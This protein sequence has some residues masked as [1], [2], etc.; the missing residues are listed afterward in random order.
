[1]SRNHTVARITALM[2]MTAMA[3]VSV[4]AL[5]QS[6]PPAEDEGEILVTGD[7]F[8]NSLINRLPIEPQELPFSLDIVDRSKMEER[9]FINPLDIL[10]TLPNVVRRQTQNLPT[11]GSY[12][13]RGL[14]ATV[15]TN[16]RP[17]NDSRGAG[18]RDASQ[19]ERF[20][21][22]KGPASILLG[23]VIPG[24]VI[25]QVTK[26][27]QDNDFLN[28]TARGGS[29]GTYRLEADANAGTLLGSDVLSGR[30]TLAYEDQQTPQ[31]P[32]K[33]ETFS[34]RPVVEANF[35]DRTR[36][37]ASVAYTRRDSVPGSSFPVNAD[38]SV[39]DVFDAKTLDRKSVV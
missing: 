2:S 9:G 11:G 1:M 16:N 27:P 23:P 39:P 25:N 24:G 21:V 22:V 28:V 20:E 33:T 3:T 6:E 10:E 4:P 35:S 15:L 26:S 7:R 37:Q 19:I 38:G 32:E 12:L 30:I 36:A 34:I 18:R 8:Q 13:I 5:A 17:E 29:Y 14:Y 31:D